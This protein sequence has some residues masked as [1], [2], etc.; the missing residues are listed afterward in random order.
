MTQLPPHPPDPRADRH[1]PPAGAARRL[2]SR[3]LLGEER[4]LLI[5]HHGELYRLRLT[6]A[7]KLILTK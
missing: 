4:E 6:R 7:G 5:D 1:P 2:D 3:A